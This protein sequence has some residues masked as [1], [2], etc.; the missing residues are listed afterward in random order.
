MRARFEKQIREA[1][2]S[3][4]AAIEELDGTKFRQDAWTRSG[5]GGGITRI[6][7]VIRARLNEPEA[8]AMKSAT[9]QIPYLIGAV[10]FAPVIRLPFPLHRAAPTTLSVA[11]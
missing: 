10:V 7:Q 2:N 5:G 3:I 9:H 11:S 4:C 8:K 6:M 1:Q